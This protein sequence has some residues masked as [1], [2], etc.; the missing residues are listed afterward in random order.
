MAETVNIPSLAMGAMW[1]R[2]SETAAGRRKSP[3]KGVGYEI[4]RQIRRSSR[5]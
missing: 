2:S 4:G 3:L 5:T 1:R